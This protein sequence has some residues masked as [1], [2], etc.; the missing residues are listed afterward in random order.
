MNCSLLHALASVQEVKGF[1]QNYYYVTIMN[2][3][4]AKPLWFSVLFN[5]Y[6]LLTWLLLSTRTIVDIRVLLTQRIHLLLEGKT[7]VN[8]LMRRAEGFS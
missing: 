4:T 7:F 6:I 5:F 1:K 3:D 2:R 8:I